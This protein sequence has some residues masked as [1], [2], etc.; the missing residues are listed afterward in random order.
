[1]KNYIFLVL[2][3]LVFVSCD[4]TSNSENKLKIEQEEYFNP[5]DYSDFQLDSINS[6]FVDSALTFFNQNK[7]KKDSMF[8]FGLTTVDFFVQKDRFPSFFTFYH[9]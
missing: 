9:K 8:V 7:I 5:L 2:C 6:H 4:K 1:M 3:L